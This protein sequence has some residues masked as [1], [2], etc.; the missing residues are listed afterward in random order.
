MSWFGS[1]PKVQRFLCGSLFHISTRFHEHRSDP[2][3][4]QTD[5]QT[6]VKAS[7]SCRNGGIKNYYNVKLFSTIWA[8]I[9]SWA[10]TQ[11][12]ITCKAIITLCA[13]AFIHYEL[14]LHLSYYIVS[15]YIHDGKHVVLVIVQITLRLFLS[16]VAGCSLAN[17]MFLLPPTRTK[18]TPAPQPVQLKMFT[19][20]FSF[21]FGKN[22]SD[23]SST[24]FSVCWLGARE[25]C[26]LIV[27]SLVDGGA[28]MLLVTSWLFWNCLLHTEC[29]MNDQYAICLHCSTVTVRFFVFFIQ[30]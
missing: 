2:A 24:V 8:V 4:R 28:C 27:T 30:L 17:R 22:R 15:C 13:H 21:V 3:D 11:Y 20:K 1:A 26:R 19:S 18:Q 5:R 7:P 16:F 10:V 23:S 29:W 9:T 14:F 25:G 12:Y 6:E